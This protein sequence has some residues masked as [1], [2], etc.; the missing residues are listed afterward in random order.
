M[1]ARLKRRLEALEKNLP[2]KKRD[3]RHEIEVRALATGFNFRGNG[4]AP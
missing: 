4:D 1:N 2:P 3:L